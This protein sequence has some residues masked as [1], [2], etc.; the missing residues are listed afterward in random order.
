MDPLILSRQFCPS[1]GGG[2]F[3]IET[4]LAGLDKRGSKWILEE[5]VPS[6]WCLVSSV[7]DLFSIEICAIIAQDS[8]EVNYFT[9][10]GYIL[11]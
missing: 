9:E 7:S 6:R 8:V 5:T 4:Q 11:V 3:G 1:R 2:Q 10:I